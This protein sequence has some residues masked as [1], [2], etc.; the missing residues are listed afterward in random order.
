MKV[1]GTQETVVE[2]DLRE[3]RRLVE[4]YLYKLFDI[5]QNSYIDDNGILCFTSSYG[6]ILGPVSN[7]TK[8][9]SATEKDRLFFNFMETAKKFNE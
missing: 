7:T 8:V 9:R 1:K 3:Q 5:P 4:E 6:G 2:I